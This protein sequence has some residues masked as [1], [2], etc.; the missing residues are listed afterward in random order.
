MGP[1][2]QIFN[3]L[4]L[5]FESTAR[6]ENHCLGQSS[7]NCLLPNHGGESAGSPW[8]E[9]GPIDQLPIKSHSALEGCS[10]VFELIWVQIS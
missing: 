1:G 10:F 8:E 9:F 7:W 6:F 3:S 4:P 5:P 2:I